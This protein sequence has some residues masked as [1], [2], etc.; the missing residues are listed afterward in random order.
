MRERSAESGRW[1]DQKS[2]KVVR[3]E[4]RDEKE[5]RR[6]REEKRKRERRE[7]RDVF[8]LLSEEEK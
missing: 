5:K 7:R 1:R 6:K 3:S 8:G 4:R 2:G